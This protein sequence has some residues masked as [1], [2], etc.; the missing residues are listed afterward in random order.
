MKFVAAVE[1]GL[2]QWVTFSGRASRSEYWYFTLFYVVMMLLV[3]V[4]NRSLKVLGPATKGSLPLLLLGIVASLI[5]IACI[6]W[7]FCA[8]ISVLVR[9]LHDVNHSGWWYWISLT[10]IGAIFPLLVWSCRKGT[11]G[12]NDYG[13]DPLQHDHESASA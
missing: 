12:M 8:A 9:R 11:A 1:S 6:V 13:A 7:L 4:A 2:H 10:G 3:H 5:I